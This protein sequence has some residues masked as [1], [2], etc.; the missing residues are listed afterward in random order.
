MNTSHIIVSM[1]GPIRVLSLV[2]KEG[3]IVN[4]MVFNGVKKL[5]RVSRESTA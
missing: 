2:L 5:R 1:N 3:G 4:G